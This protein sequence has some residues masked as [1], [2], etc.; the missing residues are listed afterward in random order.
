MMIRR[1]AGI[2][3]KMSRHGNAKVLDILRTTGIESEVKLPNDSKALA[4]PVVLSGRLRLRSRDLKLVLLDWNPKLANCNCG[5]SYLI[6]LG[7]SFLIF[8]AKII[9]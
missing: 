9:K 5:A 7:V 3:N 6:S 1:G 2:E 8:K 4:S